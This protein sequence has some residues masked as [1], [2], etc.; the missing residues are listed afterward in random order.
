MLVI[1]AVIVAATAAIAVSQLATQMAK[2]AP[3]EHAFK[4]TQQDVCTHNGNGRSVDCGS[5]DGKGNDVQ[6]NTITCRTHGNDVD[7]S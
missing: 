5:D 4:E 2:A 1:A 6:K 3:N 7:C